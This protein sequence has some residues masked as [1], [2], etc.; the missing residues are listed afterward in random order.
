MLVYQRVIVMPEKEQ[1]KDIQ[2][3]LNHQRRPTVCKTTTTTIDLFIRLPPV[4]ICG[5]EE[6]Y[7]QEA[8]IFS[9][10]LFMPILMI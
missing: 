5:D 10:R 6:T 7:S 4:P 8:T 2:S 9:C 3:I 1:S